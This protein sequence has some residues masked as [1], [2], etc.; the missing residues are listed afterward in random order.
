MNVICGIGD[1]SLYKPQVEYLMYASNRAVTYHIIEDKSEENK[2]N[3][4]QLQRWN[5]TSGTNA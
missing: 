2:A 3:K 1:V 4:A 5:L